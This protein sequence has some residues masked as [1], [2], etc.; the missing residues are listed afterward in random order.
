MSPRYSILFVERGHIIPSNI[1]AKRLYVKHNDIVQAFKNWGDNDYPQEFFYKTDEGELSRGG[2]YDIGLV[3]W[4]YQGGH[5]H[6]KG[7]PLD[8][9]VLIK[10]RSWGIVH[11]TGK[12][13]YRQLNIPRIYFNL[14]V[15][16]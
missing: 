8:F 4:N 6:S 12:I 13:A 15:L 7:I 16:A 11:A 2:T 1:I 14:G 9:G 3:I 5:P 10:S